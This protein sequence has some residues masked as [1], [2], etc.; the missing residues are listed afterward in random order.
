MEVT[1]CVIAVNQDLE[2]GRM[3]EKATTLSKD[4]FDDLF[5]ACTAIFA[6]KWQLSIIVCLSS[7]PKCFGEILSYHQ[8]LSKKVLSTNLHKL[9]SKGVI[10]R[11]VFED[12]NINRVSYSLTDA[13]NELIPILEQLLVWGNKY[14]PYSKDDKSKYD[15]EK[16]AEDKTE[17]R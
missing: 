7:S 15:K 8:G 13:G 3:E 14:A 16:F 10:A 11:K 9:E 5:F 17:N 12:G 4:N 6:R 2:D 1:N